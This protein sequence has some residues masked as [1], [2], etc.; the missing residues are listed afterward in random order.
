MSYV[1]LCCLFQEFTQTITARAASGQVEEQ[2]ARTAS[3]RDSPRKGSMCRLE[4]FIKNMLQMYCLAF[5]GI[6]P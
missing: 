1:S 5:Q 2:L 4:K 3:I 6:F